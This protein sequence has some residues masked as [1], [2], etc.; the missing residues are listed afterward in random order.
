MPTSLPPSATE[1]ILSRLTETNSAWGRIYPGEPIDRQAVHTVYGGAQIFRRDS[2]RRLGDVA[3]AMLSEYAPDASSFAQVVGLE[4]AAAH[5][6]GGLRSPVTPALAQRIYERVLEKLRREPVEDFRIDFEDGYGTRPDAEED[7]HAEQ[8][9]AEVA[10]GMADRILPPF[11]GIRIKNFGEGTVER[12]VRT[13]DLFLTTLAKQTGGRPPDNFVVMLPKVVSA[14]QVTAL[15]DLFELFEGAGT[16]PRGS[17]RMEFM[18]E[19][20]QSVIDS[21]GKCPLPDFVRAARGRCIAA[22]LGVYDYT[23]SCSITAQEQR[24]DHGACD[25]ARHVMQVSLGASG[26]YLADG[27]TN[28]M[29]APPHRP[30]EGRGLTAQQQ[31]ENRDVVHAAWRLHFQ[32]VR[33]SLAHGYYQGWDL[34]PAQ[35]PTRYAAVYSY[36]LESL[37]GATARLRNFVD[38][39]ARATLAGS[40]FDDAATA[41]GLLTFF[42]QG[43]RRRAITEEEVAATGLT[44]EEMRQRSFAAILAK[45]ARGGG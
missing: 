15:V 21:T 11:I 26:L 30:A 40:V 4:S 33:R 22:A 18:V 35:L 25:F 28:I 1:P 31:T 29:P 24:I 27:A 6:P 2:A 8:A 12:G 3:L 14:Q 38:K 37:D 43:L 13:L 45:R 39:A 32:H 41:Q 7:L 16:F 19:T 20:T 9:A 34:N 17:L 42:L 10:S 5:L 36:F 44:V 23:A